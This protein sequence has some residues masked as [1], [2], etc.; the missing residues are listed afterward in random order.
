MTQT[1]LTRWRAV[2]YTD[3]GGDGEPV[4]LIH[5]GGLADWFTPLAAEPALRDH[6]VIRMVRAGYTGV[7]APAGLTVAGH[8]EHAAALL[9]HLGAAPAHVVAHSSGATVALQLA[10]DHPEAVRTLTLCEPPLVAPLVDP[11]DH[12]LLRAAFGPAIGSVMAAAA[13]GD[14]PAA[15]DTFM[16]LVC[17][18]GHRRVMT[19][20]LGVAPVADAVARS[21]YFFAEEMPAV[22]AW[23]VE[24][25]D[26]GKVRPPVLL[27]Q[28]DASPPPVHRLITH[29]AGLI[30]GATVAT[31]DGAGHLMP[32]T[33]SASLA[34]LVAG[35]GHE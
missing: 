8:S 22:D 2:A 25:A 4:L 16:T 17:G 9:D 33:D 21:R 13:R 6:R 12:E 15:F 14:L 27:V 11:V 29:L 30:P 3:S 5:G 28:G 20:T 7:P 32:L 34:Q 1:T 18:P 24:P 26:L 23:T 31:I 35:F 10:L 19:E